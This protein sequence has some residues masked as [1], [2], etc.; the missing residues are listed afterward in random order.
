VS[1]LGTEPRYSALDHGAISPAPNSPLFK[2]ILGLGGSSASGVLA[3]H[4]DLNLIPTSHVKTKTPWA[5]KWA[6]VIPALG[7]RDRRLLEAHWLASLAHLV[8]SRPVRDPVAKKG[9]WYL[10]K[11]P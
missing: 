2:G 3:L 5:Q 1:V 9:G 7:S 10:K 8:S 4:E 6:F 11:D